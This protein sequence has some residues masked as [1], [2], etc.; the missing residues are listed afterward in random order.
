MNTTEMLW[1]GDGFSTGRKQIGRRVNIDGRKGVV[2]DGSD[3]TITI[4]W[5]DGFFK[6]L[7]DKLTGKGPFVEGEDW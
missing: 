6:R 4:R 2:V 3:L 1:T 7:W 5:D